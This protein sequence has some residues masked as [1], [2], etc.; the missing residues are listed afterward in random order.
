MNRFEGEY[1]KVDPDMSDFHGWGHFSQIVWK[2]TTQ[3]GCATV[4]CPNGLGGAGSGVA[5]YYTVCNYLMP[6]QSPFH[7][8]NASSLT[9]GDPGNWKGQYA[10][11]VGRSL[12]HPTVYWDY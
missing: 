12:N 2:E 5:P 7:T 9:G 11:N 4:D 8:Q 3:V 6:G 1:G 10:K